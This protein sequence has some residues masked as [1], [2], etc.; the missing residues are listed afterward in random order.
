MNRLNKVIDIFGMHGLAIFHAL[1]PLILSMFIVPIF[2]LPIG[3]ILTVLIINALLSMIIVMIDMSTC[4]SE[5]KNK[6]RYVQKLLIINP[7]LSITILMIF[8]ITIIFDG[9]INII[10]SIGK[11]AKN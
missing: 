1:F 4:T 6:G 3:L 10:R 5:I 11:W 2:K 7:T 9:I 8:M